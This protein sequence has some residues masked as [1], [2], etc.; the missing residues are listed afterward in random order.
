MTSAIRR[1]DFRGFRSGG[2]APDT[3]DLDLLDQVVGHLKD[4][5]L[6]AYPTETVYGFGCSLDPAA[7][8]RLRHLKGR[9]DGKPVLA[10]VPDAESASELT[11]SPQARELARVFWPGAVTLILDDPARRF[12]EGVRG[13][14]GTVA[15]RQ[16]SHPVAAA[17]VERLG[18]P[19]TSSSA[20]QAGQPPATSGQELIGLLESFGPAGRE[21]WVID[22]GTLPASAPSTLIDCTGPSPRVGRAGATPADRIRCLIPELLDA[23]T[24]V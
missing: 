21:A 12:P 23:T 14:E 5:G 2:E 1:L 15:I 20:N 10:L 3:A 13:P 17:I 4:G 7:I 24:D 18:A 9:P 16:T 6:I 22:A 19:I 11:W 8:D